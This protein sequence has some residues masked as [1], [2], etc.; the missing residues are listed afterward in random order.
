MEHYKM[1]IGASWD[2]AASG[3]WIESA[4]PFSGEVWAKIP[5]GN[6][7]D[8]DKAVQA[9]HAAF[10]S[11]A[12][13]GLTATQ[14][15]ALLRKLGDL[16]ERDAQRLASIEQRCNGKNITEVSGQVKNVAQWFYYYAGLADKI[17][18]DVVPINKP[19]VFNYVRYEPL[20]VVVA[21]T[22]WNSPLAL[23]A[24]KLSQAL[25]CGNTVVVKPSEYT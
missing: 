1:L 22:P 16:I 23:T 21:I 18:G 6:A 2:E 24:W 10:T 9:A 3:E 13:S 8:A 15:G 20:G 11:P 19:G 12:W 4:E 5:R 17:H 25:A 7:A 14:R